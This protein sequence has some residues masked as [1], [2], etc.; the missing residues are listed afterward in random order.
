MDNP[1]LVTGAAGGSQGATGNRLVRL[2]REKGIPVRAFVRKVDQRSDV[3]REMGAEVFAGDLVSIQSVREALKGIEKVYFCYPVQ[4]DLLEATAI[5]AQAAKE[6]GV[7]F[8]FQLSSGASSDQSPSPWG[9]KAWLSEQILEWSGVPTFHLRPAL[10]LESLLRQ[11]AKGI[12]EDSEIRAPFGSGNGK[13]PSIAAEDVARL[14]LKVLLKPEPFM[15]KAYQLF[16]SSHSLNELARE[17]GTL[18][19]RSIR[20]REITSDELVKET[21][22]RE[23]PANQEGKDH[24][25]SLWES[26]LN[27]NRD[28]AFLA[29][30]AQGHGAFKKITGESPTPLVEWLKLNRTAI[31]GDGTFQSNRKPVNAR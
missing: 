15:G 3:L 19:G 26:F 12:G 14:A 20:Y 27:L 6:E 30:M 1:I 25:I 29:R 31:E 18:L 4:A 21:I 9:R 2:L 10:F 13:V 5:L 28:Q 17:L 23:G 24:L 22:D 11:F 7:K 16:T 8:I